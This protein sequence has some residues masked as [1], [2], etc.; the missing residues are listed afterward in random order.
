MKKVLWSVFETLQTVTIAIVAVFL[1][2]TFI[3]QPFLVSGSSM[4]PNFSD[5]DY[6]LVDELTYRF[7]EP[8]RGEVVVFKYPGNLKSYY[9]KRIIGLPGDRVIGRDGRVVIFREGQEKTLEEPY[10]ALGKSH[11]SFDVTLMPGQFFVMGDNRDFS[12]DSRAWGSLPQDDLVGMV[13]FSLL[14]IRAAMAF[15]TPLYR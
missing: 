1:V 2:R 6:L 14:P 11:D 7:R 15:T 5:G 13:R 12:S 4:H 9:I 3:A 10:V 8:D